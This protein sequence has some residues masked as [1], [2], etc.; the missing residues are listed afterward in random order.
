MD[1]DKMVEISFQIIGYAGDARGIAMEAISEARE[2]NI[3]QAKDMI[4]E[5]KEEINKAHTYQ[6]ELITNEANGEKN[7]FSVLL[8]HSQDHLMT[9]LTVIDLAEQFV[10]VYEQLQA[11]QK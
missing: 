4:K 7:E 5:A 11:T 10:Y 2:G 6:T 1:N 8:I 3:E 9:G